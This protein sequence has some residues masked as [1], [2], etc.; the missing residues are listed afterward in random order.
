MLRIFL[1]C[2]VAFTGGQIVAQKKS[3]K[4]ITANH[5]VLEISTR[6]L[7]EIRLENG[8]NAVIEVRLMAENATKQFIIFEEQDAKLTLQ[9]K[10]PSLKIQ[11]GVFRKFITERLQRGSAVVKIPLNQSVLIS[12]E[13]CNVTSKASLKNLTID[14][15]NSSIRIHQNPTDAFIQFYAGNFYATLSD[16]TYTV[17][18]N[19]GT[20]R[21]NQVKQKNHFE[22]PSKQSSSKM[23]VKTIKGNIF[24]TSK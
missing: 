8:D 18:T 4:S 23:T 19:T 11:D 24:L 21:L 2:L 22:I 9:F 6:G 7:D 5:E 1:Y 10:F 15:V 14:V 3:F 16:Q 17:Q 12:G 20:V 13:N